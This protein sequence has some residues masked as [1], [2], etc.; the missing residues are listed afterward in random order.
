[1]IMAAE[2]SMEHLLAENFM[3]ANELSVA[4]QASEISAQLVVKQFVEMEAVHRRLEKMI[5]RERALKGRLEKLNAIVKAIN[6][7]V[8]FDALLNTILAEARVIPGVE[9]ASVLVLDPDRN[10]FRFMASLN[11]EAEKQAMEG[12]ELTPQEAEERYVVG[13]M[14]VGEDIFLVGNISGRTGQEKMRPLGLPEAM[15]VARIRIEGR[16]EAYFIFENKQHPEAFGPEA[17]GL[18]KDLM[19]DLKEHFV[20]AFIKARTTDLLKRLLRETNESRERAEVATRSKS[21]FLA[22]MSHEIRTPMNAILG[23]AGLALKQDLNPKLQDY[24]QKIASSGHHLL[25]IIND[26]LDFSKIEANKLELEC[27]PFQLLDVLSQVADMFS[28]RA[29]EKDLEL[30][31]G[32]SSGVDGWLVGDPLRLGQILVNLMGNALKFTRQGHIQLKVEVADRMEDR[33]RL[34]FTVEDSG[35]GMTPEQISKLFKA[36]SQADTSTTREFGGT[37]LGLSISKRLVE[38]MGGEFQVASTPGIGSSFAFTSEFSISEAPSVVIRKAPEDV[39]G[40]R[41]L[42][43]DDSALAREM[44]EDQL[45][46]FG[47]C[48]T[49]V[50]SG[51]YALKALEENV[52]DLV[53]MDWKMPGMD[54]IETTRRIKENPRLAAIPEVI[55]VTAFGREEVMMAAERTGIR[56]F[57]IKPVNPSLLLDSILEVLGRQAVGSVIGHK[58]LGISTAEKSIAGAHVLLVEDNLINQQVAVEILESAHV[59]VDIAS[60]GR[61]AVRMVDLKHYGA[62]LMDIQMP[63]MDGYEATAQIREKNQHENLPIIAMTAHAISGYRDECLAAGMNDYLTKPIEPQRLFETLAMW[64][65]DGGRMLGGEP[66]SACESELPEPRTSADCPLSLEALQQVMDVPQALAR[67]NGKESLLLSILKNFLGEVPRPEDS[68]AAAVETGN[69]AAGFRLAHTLKGVAANLAFAE[70]SEAAHELEKLMRTGTTEGCD[71]PL[72]RLMVAMARIRVLAES[73]LSKEPPMVDIEGKQVDQDPGTALRLLLEVDS[74]LKQ[75]SYQAKR[76]FER[77]VPILIG[78][79][80]QEL[81]E[82]AQAHLD[83]MDLSSARKSLRPL[84]EIWRNSVSLESSPIDHRPS[85]I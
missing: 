20:S 66:P 44:L 48:A 51:E 40:L 16:A 84:V 63:E 65:H 5:A 54:G 4:H 80:A 61:E 45:Q 12:I 21:E 7:K 69:A 82:E 83:R 23:F 73:L 35:I 67:L 71:V 10:R 27:V 18:M 68:I 43:V 81:L 30:I 11:W 59:R 41:I 62:V 37:G 1:M 25:G 50:G 34:R 14:V 3:L 24:L 74:L 79:G 36:F 49:T 8:D 72:F 52:F 19:K 77:L 31:V 46:G 85:N 17:I 56:A 22:N 58:H 9:A 75:N 13:S 53:L 32:A 60:N 55:M 29:A 2:R 15:M 57:L 47:F 6:Q 76:A 78:I 26:I 42:V 39:K 38:K 64:L 28:E 70:V 33:I